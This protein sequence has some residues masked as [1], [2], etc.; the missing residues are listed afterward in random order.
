MYSYL[1]IFMYIIDYYELLSIL[2]QLFM[3]DL[4]LDNYA[5]I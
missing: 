4:S 3:M 2:Y 1:D 5:V